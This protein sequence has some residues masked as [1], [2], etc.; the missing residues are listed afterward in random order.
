MKLGNKVKFK[1]GDNVV[2]GV[3]IGERDKNYLVD[4]ETINGIPQ[5]HK[6][7]ITVTAATVLNYLLR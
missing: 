5:E 1:Y 7:V 2:V 6:T 3:L 4:V